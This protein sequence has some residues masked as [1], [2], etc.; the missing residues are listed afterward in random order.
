FRQHLRYLA[1]LTPAQRQEA[2]TDAGLSFSRMSLIQQQQF[3][4]LGFDPDSAPLQSPEEL[5]GAALRVEYA[6]PGGFQWGGAERPG[7]G[8]SLRWVVPL[9]PGR[10]GR[11]VPRPAIRARTRETVLQAVRRVDPGI[12]TALL[13]AM[14]RVDPRTELAPHVVEEDQIFPTKLGL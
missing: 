6:Q 11:R 13:E 4:A 3:L 14:H 8:L 5:A 2:Q 12:R 10:R 7:E 1:A 9:E